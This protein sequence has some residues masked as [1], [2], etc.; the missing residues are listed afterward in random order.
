MRPESRRWHFGVLTTG[1]P[2]HLN[3][4]IALAH[5]LAGRGHGVTFFGKPRSESLVRQ[6]GFDFVPL[7]TDASAPEQ[8]GVSQP[9]M[10]AEIALLRSR[11][12]RMQAEIETYLDRTV[13][14]VATAG[15]T[16]LLVDEI[17]L[18]GPSVA[19][20]L[21]IPYFIVSTSVPHRFG[22]RNTSWLTGYRIADSAWSW[23]E[24]VFL[25]LSVLRTRGPVRATI[26]QFRAAAGLGSMRRI[27]HDYPCLAHIAQWPRCLDDSQRRAPPDFFYAGPFVDGSLR[28][29]VDFPWERLDGRPLIYASLGTTSRIRPA[30][31]R[32]IA[33]ACSS[34]DAQ[35]VISTGGHSLPGE[36]ESLP[37]DPV[38]VCYVPQLELLE[39]ADL[40]I[41]HAGLNT[42]LETL[43]A[44]KPMVA[45]PLAFD[46]PAVAARLRQLGVAEVLPVMR[47]SSQRIRRAVEKVLLQPSYADAAKRLQSALCALRGAEY[48]A[49][50]VER[51]LDRHAPG[52]ETTKTGSTQLR[53]PQS[54]GVH[55]RS[56]RVRAS[57]SSSSTA[58]LR[59]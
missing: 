12:H 13:Q 56:H 27:Q 54:P 50:V 39:R 15:A 46:Q 55:W 35:L 11:L 28:M 3:P 48:A 36:F 53:H 30:I 8:C 6:A 49:T 24:S 47:L 37:G 25:E 26:D 5:E 14:A 58:S 59:S 9:G 57:K 31:L 45:I 23:L 44:G 17:A 10:W 32:M 34:F 29:R 38:I 19:Q 40:V 41:T 22:W 51:A 16:A 4:L 20:V 2:G 21:G 52:H 42:V 33:Q 43:M 7:A 1:G 18:S